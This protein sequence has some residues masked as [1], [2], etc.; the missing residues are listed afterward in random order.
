[1]SGNLT[2]FEQLINDSDKRLLTLSLIYKENK[3]YV[4][5]RLWE[6]FIRNVAAI[7]SLLAD[8]FYDE[9]YSIQRLSLEHMF[10]F[11]AFI[12][13]DNF[14]DEFHNNSEISF[15]KTLNALRTSMAKREEDPLTLENRSKLEEQIAKYKENSVV[16]LGYSF[17]NVANKSELA[18]FY[19][20]QYRLLSLSYAHSTFISVS[21]PIKEED[22]QILLKS[23]AAHMEIMYVKSFVVWAEHEE[24]A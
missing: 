9:A 4:M 12:E 18:P 22:I 24:Q 20:S 23:V 14:M 10:N 21:Q 19:D 17:F 7:R 16:S 11:F 8:G 5:L 15:P 3:D 13:D 6:K 2:N 1:M